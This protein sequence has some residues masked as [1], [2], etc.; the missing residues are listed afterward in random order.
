M[1]RQETSCQSAGRGTGFCCTH[2]ELSIL[3]NN[4][5][6]GLITGVYPSVEE[7]SCGRSYCEKYW[8][9]S[10]SLIILS[11]TICRR[12]LKPPAQRHRSNPSTFLHLTYCTISSIL[13]LVMSLK[14]PLS[15]YTTLTRSL[16]PCT[17]S[18]SRLSPFRPI[19]TS[20]PIST[21]PSQFS[22]IPRPNSSSIPP[23]FTPRVLPSR[24]SGAT[25]NSILGPS[26]SS[27]VF[28]QVFR[29][30]FSSSRSGLIRQTYFPKS[31]GYGGGGQSSGGWFRN[32]RRRID[33]LPTIAVVS[34]ALNL[35]K[36]QSRR[37]Q[38]TTRRRADIS[39]ICHHSSKRCRVPAMA[40]RSSIMAT[41]PRS[42]TTSF[43]HQELCAQ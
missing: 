20:R 43:P 15:L 24:L 26:G 21:S 27:T 16:T 1:L 18:S 33:R 6:L 36:I 31:S 37:I 10:T 4:D 32:L 2:S 8:T 5:R 35:L 11:I 30:A 12:N 41:I 28:A 3:G 29:R 40:I 19:L 38:S 34:S 14:Q 39:G 23:F 7:L 42:I 17:S 22:P 9:A 25:A 13:G